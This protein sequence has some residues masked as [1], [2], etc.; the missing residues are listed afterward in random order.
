MVWKCDLNQ[1]IFLR[2]YFFVY[3]LVLVSIEKTYQTLETSQL[4]SVPCIHMNVFFIYQIYLHI[5]DKNEV[6]CLI[7]SIVSTCQYYSLV[8]IKM[9]TY[10][11]LPNRILIHEKNYRIV[12]H[13]KNYRIVI[14][15]KNHSIVIHEKNHSI[16]I[17][18]KHYS[19]V[20]H[21]KNYRIV[22]HEEIT[23]Q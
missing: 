10:C 3:S 5:I 22:M 20:I 2:F 9:G 8:T 14:H 21:E 4:T 13:E 17:H 11:Y 6:D 12:I 1:L 7:T 18:E 16:V 23:V 15:E 19:I